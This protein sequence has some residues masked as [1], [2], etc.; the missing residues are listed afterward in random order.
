MHPAYT[1]RADKASSEVATLALSYLRSLLTVAGPVNANLRAAF[2]F[3]STPRYHRRRSGYDSDDGLS[4]DAS[5]DER[6]RDRDRITGS[7]ANAHSVWSRGQDF[8]STIGWAFNCSALHPQRWRYWKVW[9]EFMLDVLEED[10]AERERLDME[11]HDDTKGGGS[12]ST[13][14]TTMREQS[15]LLMYMEQRN[16]PQGGFKAIMKALFADG[17]SLS[18][19]SFHEVFEKEPRARRQD[20]ATMKKRKR[21]DKVDVEND[22]FGDYLDD[23]IFSSGASEP[24]TP[25]KPRRRPKTTAVAFAAGLTESVPLR[26]RLFKLLS[27]AT[28]TLRKA[29]DVDRLYDAYAS[30]LK[31]LPLDMFALFTAQRRNPMA[32][33]LHVT[34]LKVLF[35]LLLPSSYKDPYRVDREGEMEGRLSTAMLV[36]CYVA[37]P[38]NTIGIEDNAKL[39]LVVEAALQLLWAE[40]MLEYSAALDGAVRRGI[41]ARQHKIRRKRTGRANL[42][43]DD[44][45]AMEVLDASGNRLELLLDAIQATASDDEEDDG[46]VA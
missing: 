45:Q 30:S 37:H 12:T 13:A 40:G 33:A 22:R 38:A 21:E 20:E 4:D 6:D 42:D 2:Q 3:Y 11:A 36:H 25:E 43:P 1:N 31:V 35:R 34:V 41:E 44:V 24:P 23:D 9:V 28:F 7:L 17:G 10:W 39:S 18:T 5:T 32:A 46:A 19:S 14:P 15:I 8:W 29:T 16:G 27:A 26:L